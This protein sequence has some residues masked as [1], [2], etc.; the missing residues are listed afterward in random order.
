MNNLPQLQQEMEAQD[1]VIAEAGACKVGRRSNLF[2][3]APKYLPPVRGSEEEEE[4]A[5][6]RKKKHTQKKLAE[7]ICFY[8]PPFSPSI[9]I[10]LTLQV[11]FGFFRC[12]FAP[13]PQHKIEGA[14]ENKRSSSSV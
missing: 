6:A 9:N 5:V 14:N 10:I 7:F 2:C 12:E 1:A 8:H 3:A 4:E 13:S 11:R